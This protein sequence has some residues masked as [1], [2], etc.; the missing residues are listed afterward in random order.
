LAVLAVGIPALGTTFCP[1]PIDE[2]LKHNFDLL[3]S[4]HLTAIAGALAGNIE[5]YVINF[6]RANVRRTGILRPQHISPQRRL[7]TKNTTV[8]AGGL[9]R[10]QRYARGA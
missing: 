8:V 3:M 7:R 6:S 10:S 4:R 5:V 2:R 1:R 9:V